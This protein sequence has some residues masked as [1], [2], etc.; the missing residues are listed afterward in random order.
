MLSTSIVSKLQHTYPARSK[1]VISKVDEKCSKVSKRL[2]SDS[3]VEKKSL[4]IN[5]GKAGIAQHSILKGLKEGY[6]IYP[7][8]PD[9]PQFQHK[10]IDWQLMPI[11]ESAKVENWKKDRKSVV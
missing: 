9:A 6:K 2:F 1:T 8:I 11:A 5:G 3:K 10:N 4:V 7:C